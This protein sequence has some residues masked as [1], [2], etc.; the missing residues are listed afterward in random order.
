MK[1]AATGETLMPSLPADASMLCFR[2]RW[3]LK[4]N[5]SLPSAEFLNYFLHPFSFC[6]FFNVVKAGRERFDECT[7]IAVVNDRHC[8]LGIH[9]KL[10]RRAVE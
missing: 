3:L 10:V 7:F 9:R 6:F 8:P 5:V 2:K 1:G 4:E